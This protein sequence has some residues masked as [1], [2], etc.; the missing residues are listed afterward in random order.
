MRG[1]V[2]EAGLAFVVSVCVAA[3][4]VGFGAYW[5]AAFAASSAYWSFIA[6][7]LYA[8]RDRRSPWGGS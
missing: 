5:V 8:A 3:F 6:A 2:V 7:R 1:H 4:A